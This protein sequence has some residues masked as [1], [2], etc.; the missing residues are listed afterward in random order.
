VISGRSSPAVQNYL[1]GM[2]KQTAARLKVASFDTR[3]PSAFARMFGNAATRTVKQLAGLG[4]R[5]IAKPEGFIVQGQKG[6]LAVGEIDRAAR[7]GSDL[8]KL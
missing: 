2:T 3:L 8:S 7:W 5:V 1:K 6:P 4:S